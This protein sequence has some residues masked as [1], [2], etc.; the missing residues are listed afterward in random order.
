MHSEV[1]HESFL[2]WDCSCHLTQSWSGPTEASAIVHV[3]NCFNTMALLPS[4][5]WC[6]VIYF[7][8]FPTGTTLQK[9][10]GGGQ[11]QTDTEEHRLV[12]F[13]IH[14]PIQFKGRT[15]VSV[16]NYDQEYSVSSFL[17]SP[18]E[19]FTIPLISCKLLLPFTLHCGETWPNKKFLPGQLT[20]ID[21]R[22]RAGVAMSC[23]QWQCPVGQHWPQGWD[24]ITPK[25][26]VHH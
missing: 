4:Q 1:F 9:H 5:S 10:K 8:V 22:T 2:L 17:H 13:S 15:R 23:R 20:N 18:V 14:L 11:H 26:S 21:I 25:I 12:S 3:K 7:P 19:I 16:S 6:K 24:E